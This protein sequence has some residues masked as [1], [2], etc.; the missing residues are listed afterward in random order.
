MVEPAEALLRVT[1]AEY[2]KLKDE[3]RARIGVRDNLIYAALVAGA[4]VAG[5]TATRGTAAFLLLLPPVSALLG[6][7]YLMNDHKISQLGKYFRSN[8]R[9]A[10]TALTGQPALGWEYRDLNRRRSVRK[11]LQLGFD[12][13]AFTV[14]P[15][16]ALVAYWTAG[17]RTA[18]FLAVSAAETGL[19]GVV[20]AAIVYYVEVD[21]RRR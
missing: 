19:L 16:A 4:A 10:L 2:E 7:T 20:A 18:P 15:L 3:Q 14:L 5:A 6:W 13:L 17:P 12:L 9:P 11:R 8:T 1:L 21:W